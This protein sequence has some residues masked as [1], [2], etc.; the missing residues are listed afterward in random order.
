MALGSL[1]SNKFRSALDV[2]GIVV[3]IITVV[4]VGFHPDRDCVRASPR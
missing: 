4:L 3:G 1:R 2:L